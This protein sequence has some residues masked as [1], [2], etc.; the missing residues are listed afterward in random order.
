MVGVLHDFPDVNEDPWT[1]SEV[2]V[3]EGAAGTG[4]EVTLESPRL[5]KGGGPQGNQTPGRFSRVD[6]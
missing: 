1:E 2:L 3:G 4:S 5:R 6:L